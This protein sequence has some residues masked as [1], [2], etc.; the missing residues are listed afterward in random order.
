MVGEF[1]SPLHAAFRPRA[2]SIVDLQSS[3]AHPWG[4]WQAPS[5]T[6]NTPQK[7]KKNP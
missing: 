1:L 2:R 3:V 6:K 7:S 5:T 4:G